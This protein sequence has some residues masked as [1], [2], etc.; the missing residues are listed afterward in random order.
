MVR[1][2]IPFHLKINHYLSTLYRS[3]IWM[4]FTTKAWKANCRRP[5]PQARYETPS[6]I[7]APEFRKPRCLRIW[8]LKS[9]IQR[10][11]ANLPA[12]SIYLT[13]AA[14]IL[15]FISR[16]FSVRSGCRISRALWKRLFF[17]GRRGLE[18]ALCRLCELRPNLFC[19][20]SLN[21]QG[22]SSTSRGLRFWTVSGAAVRKLV[23]R[24]SRFHGA[25]ILGGPQIG[26]NWSKMGRRKRPKC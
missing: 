21:R 10:F 12:F 6:C 11:P 8:G 26:L 9:R 7:I 17:C 14:F 3:R 22:C 18:L 20:T 23:G 1:R 24:I 4:K 13:V 16:S 5:Q 19:R 25:W 15:L 2:H